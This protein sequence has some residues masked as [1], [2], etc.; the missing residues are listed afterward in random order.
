MQRIISFLLL[1]FLPVTSLADGVVIPPVAYPAEVA[2]PAQSALICWS[3]GLERLVIG[4][5][6][7]GTGTN[8][9][10]VVPLPSKPTIEEASSG[11]FT[12]LEYISR[13]NIIHNVFPFH[14][15]LLIGVGVI[16]LLLNV[17]RNT[18]PRI[19]DTL[20][21]V[22]VGLAIMPLSACMA[23]P[24][25]VLLPYTVWRVRTGREAPWVILALLFILFLMSSM[26]LP[27]LGTAGV[28]ASETGVSVLSHEIIGEYDTTTI[29]AKDSQA[30]DEWLK[31]NGYAVFP[32]TDKVVSNYVSRGWI[33]VATKLQ[34][35]SA[36]QGTNWPHPLCFN[37]H[38]DK[39][40]YPMQLTG[41]GST[42][43]TV[44]LFVFGPS[45]AEAT[46]FHT[47]RCAKPLFPNPEDVLRGSTKE[48]HIVH[49]L[50]RKWVAGTA[51][52]TKLT[53]NLSPEMMSQ[54]VELR[55]APFSE[56]QLE[57]Y[58]NQGAAIF[59]LNCGTIIFVAV[60]LPASIVTGFRREW[61]PHLKRLFG[62]AV[63]TGAV[64]A[65]GVFVT[66]PKIPVRLTRLPAF[67]SIMNLRQLDLGFT[68]ESQ[69]NR[70]SSLAEARA[71]LKKVENQYPK[72]TEQNLLL[73]GAVRE[74]DSP[75]NYIL[76]QSTNGVDFVWFDADGGEH[77]L[78]K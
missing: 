24:L 59:G 37:F 29:T 65:A 44:D 48:L 73:G 46:F 41:I 35:D 49:P 70:V 69:S 50:L 28:S 12:T 52:A 51:V 67:Y 21:S 74:E 30:L 54:D 78:A 25:V 23:L 16:Y 56:Y 71:I 5:E 15:L 11:L 19:S 26:L 58:S 43:L 40:V 4:T 60:L 10:W 14:L 31:R 76:R 62:L 38:T 8:F 75:G 47:V 61:R 18:Q 3:N 68:E 27:A 32:A 77:G 72:L 57:F 13:P 33:F 20:I 53:A 55:W 39:A 34:R 45:R 1:L 22:F 17:R 36:I 42:N 64:V 9:A 6:F 7:I 2:M 63:I 66:V